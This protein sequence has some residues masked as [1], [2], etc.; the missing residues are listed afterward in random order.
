[1]FEVVSTEYQEHSSAIAII[2]SSAR[3]V[4]TPKRLPASR[5]ASRSSSAH[6]ATKHSSATVATLR[7]TTTLDQKLS[8]ITSRGTSYTGHHERHAQPRT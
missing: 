1:M 4:A 2:G 3:E 5:A 8:T 6:C 7:P